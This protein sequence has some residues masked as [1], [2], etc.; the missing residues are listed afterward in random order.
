LLVSNLPEWVDALVSPGYGRSCDPADSSSIRAQ[1]DWFAEN[2]SE[3]RNM[4]AR[5]RAKIE[6]DW[7]YEKAFAPLLE[8]L[9]C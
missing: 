2:Q 7:N 6:A 5:G 3:R 4:G 9:A 8:S 1:L